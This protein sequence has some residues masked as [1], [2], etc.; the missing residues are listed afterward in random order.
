[1]TLCNFLHEANGC[2]I[3]DTALVFFV[4]HIFNEQKALQVFISRNKLKMSNTKYTM[5][6]KCFGSENSE[7]I[8]QETSIS[9]EYTF[10]LSTIYQLPAA[11]LKW[12]VLAI[13]PGRWMFAQCQFLCF[14]FVIQVL[15]FAAYFFRTIK[16][17][18]HRTIHSCCTKVF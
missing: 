6:R 15:S 10:N 17:V 18:I 2:G 7:T 8:N 3:L 9:I 13:S 11:Y 4:L 12:L 16:Y 1:M 14:T 5:I